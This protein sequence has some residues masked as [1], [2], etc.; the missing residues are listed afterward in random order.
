MHW[1]KQLHAYN[2]LMRTA[3]GN[4]EDSASHGQRISGKQALTHFLITECRS[5]VP[6]PF[7]DAAHAED[8][9]CMND[10]P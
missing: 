7:N 5:F 9:M 8:C 6:V 10:A 1:K 3:C 4:N 2:L